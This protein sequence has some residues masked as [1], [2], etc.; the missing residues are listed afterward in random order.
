MHFSWPSPGK[1]PCHTPTL[2]PSPGSSPC[3]LQPLNLHSASVQ[4]GQLATSLR[5]EGS[6]SGRRGWVHYFSQLQSLTAVPRPPSSSSLFIWI[7]GRFKWESFPWQMRAGSG[8]GAVKHTQPRQRERLL[9]ITKAVLFCSVISDVAQADLT[10]RERAER[11]NHTGTRGQCHFSVLWG[12]PLS[13][14]PSAEPQSSSSS[15]L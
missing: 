12:H 9:L 6:G 13:T 3:P 10:H 5:W 11:E 8:M 7:S 14:Q 4:A 1:T 15:A 2:W